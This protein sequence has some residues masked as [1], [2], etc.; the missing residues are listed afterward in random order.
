MSI[1]K[2]SFS[3]IVAIFTVGFLSTA[4]VASSDY[5]LSPKANSSS[6]SF[7]VTFNGLDTD[8]IG[9]SFT[10]EL[11]DTS[12]KLL[13]TQVSTLSIHANPFN[14]VFASTVSFTTTVKTE[15]TYIIELYRSADTAILLEKAT[16]EYPAFYTSNTVDQSSNSQTNTG[17]HGFYQNSANSCSSCH[18]TQAVSD[19]A[20]SNTQSLML[21]DGTYSTCSACHDGTSGAYNTFSEVNSNDVNS[22]AGTFNVQTPGQ[23]GSLHQT[24]SEIKISAAPGGNKNGGVYD[25]TFSCSSCHSVHNSVSKNLLNNNPLGWGGITYTPLPARVSIQNASSN[26]LD[27]LN[28]K[29][30][31]N[32]PIYDL[33]SIPNSYDLTGQSPT[34]GKTPYILVK[35]TASATD[36]SNFWYS[37]A[38][39]KKGDPVIQTFRWDGSKYI[40]DYS[41][42]LQELNYP[43]KA[44]T[45]FMDIN[46]NNIISAS[47]I[48]V[49]WRD[50]FAFGPGV[51]NVAS[52]NVSIGIDVE[53]PIPTDIATLYDSS[54]PNY[55]PD[56][57]VEMS[58][59][60]SACH[61]D[62][63]SVTGT[64]STGIY[65]KAQRHATAL[66]ETTCVRCHYA[67]G[68]GAQI[69]K[70][71]NDN[72]YFDLTQAGKVFDASV[73]GNTDKALSYF[74][75]PNPSSAL[76]RYTGMSVCYSCH[77]KSEQF[78][79][80]PNTN[81][82]DLTTGEYLK[83][84]D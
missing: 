48:T 66:D 64:N 54:D 55:V 56:S 49:V 35:F 20:S 51:N 15:T 58:K 79:G 34:A 73:P 16:A 47:D 38:N 25:Q 28:G 60:C 53:T 43:Y 52:A 71:A 84:G 14:T 30:F 83:N 69:M 82:A 31:E 11:K 46:D 22:I 26:E 44:N 81:Q 57:G 1:I 65:T 13:E 61:M 70:D 59:F 50:A 33:A 76:K 9:T 42:W 37:R 78:M 75:D 39:V 29:L 45:K 80:N 68:S 21:K 7:D 77:G 36:V 8:P 6:G 27:G 62:Y 32:I 74:V 10:L 72:S 5:N 18:Q 4:T 23:N 12:G 17:P 41:L 19:S 40:P 3:L 2:L 63:L 67:H 24:D